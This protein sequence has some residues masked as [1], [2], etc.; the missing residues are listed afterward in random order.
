[1]CRIRGRPTGKGWFR[2]TAALIWLKLRPNLGSTKGESQKPCDHL[3][4]SWSLCRRVPPLGQKRSCWKSWDD[5]FPDQFFQA[6]VVGIIIM[7]IFAKWFVHNIIGTYN[8]DIYPL[9]GCLFSFKKALNR[10]E[11]L[12]VSLDSSLNLSNNIQIT[13]WELIWCWFNSPLEWR[14]WGL[15]K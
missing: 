3:G 1:M 7:I 13:P 5:D 6:N 10:G 14:L 8:T 2:R 12:N 15:S 9:N 11:V 4:N